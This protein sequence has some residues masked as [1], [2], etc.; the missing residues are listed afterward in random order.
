MQEREGS[1]PVS[2]A[3][4]LL[5][6][7]SW[8]SWRLLSV[9]LLIL[10]IFQCSL[11]L[12]HFILP[13]SILGGVQ[14]ENGPLY[15]SLGHLSGGKEVRALSLALVPL[16][17]CS[18][19]CKMGP[20]L[21]TGLEYVAYRLRREG[22]GS[23]AAEL[24]LP[25]CSKVKLAPWALLGNRGW[26]LIKDPFLI[27]C[28]GGKR[29]AAAEVLE[30]L[31]YRLLWLGLVLIH[32]IVIFYEVVCVLMKALVQYKL[33]LLEH[34]FLVSFT[35]KWIFPTSCLCTHIHA[36]VCALG[37]LSG[38]KVQWKCKIL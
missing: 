6:P 15:L 33:L 14:V 2:S 25:C 7:A 3:E 38:W 22:R 10:L 29:W 30:P 28:F 13:Q 31:I 37:D 35:S 11:F 36:H 23:T 27:F 19:V 32:I 17:R 21:P 20:L 16:F 26:E 18:A 8:E 5:S 1:D 34:N 9:T 4:A 24:P 12:A